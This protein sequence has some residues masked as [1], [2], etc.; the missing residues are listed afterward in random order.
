MLCANILSIAGPDELLII[1]IFVSFALAGGF[2]ED[3]G[4]EELPVE[5][6]ESAID[7]PAIEPEP[8]AEPES[9]IEPEIIADTGME[10]SVVSCLKCI[11]ILYLLVK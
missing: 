9:A 11:F 2:E 5:Q 10:L 8:A 3:P 4:P 7:A 6:T 1:I